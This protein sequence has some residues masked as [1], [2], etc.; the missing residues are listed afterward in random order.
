MYLLICIMIWVSFCFNL[1]FNH[2][3][4][5]LPI[6]CIKI[7]VEAHKFQLSGTCLEYCWFV[8]Q[9]HLLLYPTSC[10]D[11]TKCS[12]VFL[13][14]STV[15]TCFSKAAEVPTK[16]TKKII[17]AGLLVKKAFN[18]YALMTLMIHIHSQQ[19]GAAAAWWSEWGSLILRLKVW[20]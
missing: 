13:T 20:T 5:C 19:A 4:P 2:G 7:Q 3:K 1:F 16:Q 15:C 6:P 14:Q 18:V 17:I 10:V 11:N 12:R 8:L 9:G